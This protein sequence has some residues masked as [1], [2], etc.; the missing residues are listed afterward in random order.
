MAIFMLWLM[1]NSV[2][3]CGLSVRRLS[4]SRSPIQ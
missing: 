1:S 2:P 4:P 3:F